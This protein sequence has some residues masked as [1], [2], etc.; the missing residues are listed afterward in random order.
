MIVAPTMVNGIGITHGGTIFALADAAFS[1]AANSYNE[2]T[3]AAHCSI[4]FVQPTRLGDRLVATAREV[5]RSGR[6]GIYDVSVTLEQKLIAEFRAH[7]R[8]IGGTLLGD[9]WKAAESRNQSPGQAD[10]GILRS[11]K[12]SFTEA[13]AL[14]FSTFFCGWPFI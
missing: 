13:D 14:A 7:S 1:L 2:R 3:V 12:E 10:R 11:R 6:S 4:S 9:G 5:M 8:A